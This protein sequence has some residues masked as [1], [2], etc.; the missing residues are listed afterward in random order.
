MDQANADNP[1]EKLPLVRLKVHVS[2]SMYLYNCRVKD[3]CMYMYMYI[4]T[5]C[6]F[7]CVSK[8]T[9]VHIH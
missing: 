3:I 7:V 1:R 4:E 6:M 9:L 2:L 5:I 8:N